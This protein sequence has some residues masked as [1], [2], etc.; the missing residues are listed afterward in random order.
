MAHYAHMIHVNRLQV[1]AH[2][3]FYDTERA[4]QQ[5][6]E[7][8]FRLYFSEAPSCTTSDEADFIDYGTLCKVLTDFVASGQFN[9]IE[10]MGS[11]L[12]RHLRA[13]LD[14]RDCKQV[15]LWLCLNKIE[16]PV[17]GLLGGASFSV[18]DLAAD[19]TVAIHA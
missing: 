8:S 3:G 1:P 19:D 18:S 14:G 17:P 4:K 10:F 6:V 9:L 11:E 7:I 5:T 12:F 16:A 13:Y 2:I 15:K